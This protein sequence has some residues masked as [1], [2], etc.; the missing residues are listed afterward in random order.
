M[1]D[2]SPVEL[3][4][5]EAVDVD[6]EGSTPWRER[7]SMMFTN[8][9]A[10]EEFM[11][12]FMR[13]RIVPVFVCLVGLL[14]F[15]FQF[16]FF[17]EVDY[18]A[19]G[20]TVLQGL[21]LV[22]LIGFLWIYWKL[23][24][25]SPL[26]GEPPPGMS[27]GYRRVLY[28]LYE[29]NNLCGNCTGI[30]FICTNSLTMFEA[31]RRSTDRST[32]LVNCR[33]RKLDPLPIFVFCVVSVLTPTRAP[34]LIPT[35]VLGGIINFFIGFLTAEGAGDIS[36]LL[37][38]V[39]VIT[40]IVIHFALSK[41]RMF[42]STFEQLLKTAKEI[43]VAC[44]SQEQFDFILREML[45]PVILD[46]YLEG[47]LHTD[48][49]ESGTACFS[50]IVSFTKWSSHRLPSEV[51]NMLMVIVQGYDLR[52]KQFGVEKIKTIGDGYW[53]VSGIPL[54]CE[55][56]ALAMARFAHS[57]QHFVKAA[58]GYHPEWGGKLQ[59]R[60]GIHSGMLIGGVVGSQQ[61]SYEVFGKTNMIAAEAEQ[62][63]LPGHV[64]VTES[65]MKLISDNFAFREHQ[66][67]RIT[68]QDSA[69]M[70][71]KSFHIFTVHTEEGVGEDGAA[72]PLLP[73]RI[74]ADLP[75]TPDVVD[76]TAA[77]PLIVPQQVS[78]AD[79][80]ED[81]S[82]SLTSGTRRVVNLTTIQRED[83]VADV[84]RVEQPNEEMSR[85]IAAFVRR[86]QEERNINKLI[87]QTS[88]T[89]SSS[90][91][92]AAD[93]G[94]SENSSSTFSS[95]NFTGQ[96]TFSVKVKGVH[97]AQESTFKLTFRQLWTRKWNFDAF[98]G[99]ITSGSELG[100][101]YRQAKMAVC[102]AAFYWALL[103]SAT[104]QQWGYPLISLCVGAV[105][106]FE[107]VV[108]TFRAPDSCHRMRHG[109]LLLDSL[110]IQGSAAFLTNSI[111]GGSLSYLHTLMWWIWVQVSSPFPVW[112]AWTGMVFF[113]T[114]PNLL[115]SVFVSTGFR[116]SFSIELLAFMENFVT[117]TYFLFLRERNLHT[118]LAS[119]TAM[120]H[121]REVAAKEEG[122]RDKVFHTIAPPHIQ[123]QLR[124]WILVQGMNTQRPI[125]QQL[126]QAVVMFAKVVGLV[127]TFR[128][129]DCPYYMH[130]T[131][132]TLFTDLERHISCT[133]YLVK[134]KTVGDLLIIVGPLEDGKEVDVS[135]APRAVSASA[136]DAILLS[137]TLQEKVR[138]FMSRHTKTI[139][140]RLAQ[141]PEAEHGPKPTVGTWKLTVGIHVGP[142]VGAVVGTSRIA[143]DVFGPTVNMASR[144]M[145]TS[146]LPGTVACSQEVYTICR[147][148]IDRRQEQDSLRSLSFQVASPLI[149][150][151]SSP[152]AR[153]ASATFSAP[154][155]S[156]PDFEFGPPESRFLK[157]YGN[158]D[159]YAV[160]ERSRDGEAA[161]DVVAFAESAAEG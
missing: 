131:L 111:V 130:T 155:I 47:T 87:S 107:P 24:R 68:L 129:S 80:M 106:A 26:F 115:L 61:F 83:D 17:T 23:R 94:A 65:T 126:P 128:A 33:Y 8:T 158:C 141:Q 96:K 28:R 144:L 140:E 12:F 119:H 79:E 63:A 29:V 121:A 74:V 40:G 19:E 137:F 132:A 56:H 48:V 27:V 78:F 104:V 146:K 138:T 3:V 122:L 84:L 64:L 116:E 102:I 66:T 20:G 50:D 31:C 117:G 55:G 34:T 2:P 49:V 36:V 120:K 67:L 99:I 160:H 22:W 118:V 44:K 11:R 70:E 30:V 159:V 136:V 76:L 37:F 103:I 58:N 9:I 145:S 125:H 5:W 32:L 62:N 127:D 75:E 35:L 45:P 95:S 15:T 41:E 54:L 133:E 71:M 91:A 148:E 139:E 10:E 156:H 1:S 21:T 43:L 53:A 97:D 42:R 112:L 14:T 105:F 69:V 150:T 85:R 88:D 46:R 86:E 13:S 98:R 147:N 93:F 72:S 123:G 142:V 154:D 153:P 18:V 6:V 134:I 73:R 4:D 81:D 39:S 135:G 152:H 143:Y 113:I 57:C 25:D 109:R 52:A 90:N 101:R 92:S 100:E 89:T 77:T 7:P 149:S 124:D 59:V 157:G 82:E 51:V 110:I 114:I 38:L 60:I 16:E 161:D 108:S 151:A